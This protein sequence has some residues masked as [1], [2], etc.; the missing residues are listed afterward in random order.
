MYELAA[1]E[2]IIACPEGA[3]TLV[4]CK[5]LIDD[6][7]IDADETVVLMNTGSG[8]KYMHLVGNETA[9]SADPEGG[10]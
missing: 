2:G 5:R 7:M 1:T 4:G 6:G 10:A 9:G 3:A 8:Y